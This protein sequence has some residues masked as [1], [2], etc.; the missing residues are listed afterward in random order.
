MDSKIKAYCL[1]N[2]IEIVKQAALNTA[3][4]P[5]HLPNLLEATYKKLLEI[6]V[7]VQDGTK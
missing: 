7:D 1:S 6:S 5:S 4:S 3:L 2:A